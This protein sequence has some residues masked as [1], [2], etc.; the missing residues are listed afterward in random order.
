MESVSVGSPCTPSRATSAGPSP[1]RRNPME[2]AD[3]SVTRKRPRLDSGSLAHTSMSADR[4]TATPSGTETSQDVLLPAHDDS[5]SLAG[6]QVNSLHGA[7]RTPSKVT[8]N[9]RDRGQRSSPPLPVTNGAGVASS[10]G[11]GDSSVSRRAGSPRKDDSPSSNVISVS[12]SPTRS[13]EIEI[14]EVEDMN[15]EFGETRWRPLVSLV[16]AKDTQGA[17]LDAFPFLDRTRDLRQTVALIAQ[18]FE[19]S[20]S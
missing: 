1:P 6:E 15:E 20:K 13:P 12:S 2:D 3:S 17:L 5:S 10:R 18:A 4:S 16:D 14:A 9:V 8:I 11:R 19:K 7:D